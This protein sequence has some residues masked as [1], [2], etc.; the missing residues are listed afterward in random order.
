MNPLHHLLRPEGFFTDIR[1]KGSQLHT[2][3][4]Q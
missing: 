2:G 3:E 1:K 4:S